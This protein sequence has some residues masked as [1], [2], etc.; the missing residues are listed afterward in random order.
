MTPRDL[1]FR[2][3]VLFAQLVIVA[4]ALVLTV[5]RALAIELADEVRASRNEHRNHNA[6]GGAM[7]KNRKV[8]DLDSTKMLRAMNAELAAKQGDSA[9]LI[10][11]L[12][13]AEY[14]AGNAALPI[15]RAS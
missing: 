14:Y 1:A 5:L 9:R 4:A 7:L 10:A 12:A 3:V 11:E 15:R 2:L 6:P 13:E 8:R